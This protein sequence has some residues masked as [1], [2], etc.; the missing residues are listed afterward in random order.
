VVAREVR[1]LAEASK[2]S[3]VKI[4]DVVLGIRIQLDETLAGMVAIRENTLQFESS[5]TGARKT[6]ESIRGI[7]TQIE[8]LMNSTVEDA[9]EQAV[10]T[11]AIS[12]GAGQLQS[13]IEAHAHMSADVAVT[14]DQLGQLADELRALLPKKEPRLEAAGTRTEPALAGAPLDG[15]H[16]AVA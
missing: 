1:K 12:S 8:G 10:A 7:V 5:F 4:N 14:A 9:N 13:L 11:G 15:S 6:L 2:H 3:S 16:A